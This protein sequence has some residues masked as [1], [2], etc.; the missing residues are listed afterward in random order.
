MH[1]DATLQNPW[2]PFGLSPASSSLYFVCYPQVR[3]KNRLQE[4]PPPQVGNLQRY[5]DQAVCC[6]TPS[7]GRTIIMPLFHPL[8]SFALG[9][10]V[11]ASSPSH[12][13]AIEEAIS[14]LDQST[15]Q[16]F[17]GGFRLHFSSQCHLNELIYVNPASLSSFQ[18]LDLYE[19]ALLI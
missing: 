19:P 7:S 10:P 1:Q 6:K 13:S 11:L 5:S 4:Y 12:R 2:R 14:L 9:L 17:A 15:N 3:H 8:P 16:A 18:T